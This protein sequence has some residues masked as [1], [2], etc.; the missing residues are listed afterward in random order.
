MHVLFIC[1][2]NRWR[3]PTAAKVFAHRD[4]WQVRAAGL[5]SKS[6]RVVS[7]A[8]LEWADLVFVMEHE[9]RTR[10]RERFG[11]LNVECH[12]LDIPDDYQFMDPELVSMLEERVNTYIESHASHND[13]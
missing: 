13:E 10:L 7:R 8:D 9:H 4:G 12:V 5:S 6:P 11:R 1:S 2:R 3:S